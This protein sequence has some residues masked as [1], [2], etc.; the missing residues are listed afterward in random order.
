MTH[1]G[2]G[3]PQDDA[4]RREDRSIPHDLLSDIARLLISI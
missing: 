3:P 1:F 4:S 2:A